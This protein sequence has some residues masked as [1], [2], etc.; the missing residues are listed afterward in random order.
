VIADDT[1]SFAPRAAEETGSAD[2]YLTVLVKL[3]PAEIA[4][5]YMAMRDSA[6]QHGALKV[7]FFA[8]LVACLL[9]R[10]VVSFPK[11]GP[12]RLRQVQWRSVTVS[13]VAV[14][15]W[16]FSIG[17]EKPVPYAAAGQWP[18]STVAALLS[19][20]APVPVPGD[21]AT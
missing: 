6:A 21:N 4:S 16:A 2:Y 10:S 12:H 18:A 19:L 1:A 9:L 3:V 15:R 11:E 17:S 20:I 14:Q 5:V 13:C 8:C 7:W